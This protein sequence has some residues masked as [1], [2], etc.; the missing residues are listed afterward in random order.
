M[1]AGGIRPGRKVDAGKVGAL[2]IVSIRIDQALMDRIDATA[3]EDGETRSESIRRYLGAMMLW[4]RDRAIWY[5]AQKR[6][7]ADGITPPAAL[8]RIITV[9]LT[10]AQPI[11]RPATP[12]PSRAVRAA[13][14]DAPAPTASTPPAR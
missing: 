5:T 1:L 13:R 8:V 11:R 12:D 3:R 10:A 9:A 14:L 4:R 2:M 6:A 7:Q